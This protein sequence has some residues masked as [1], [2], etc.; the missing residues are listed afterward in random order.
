MRYL[1]RWWKLPVVLVVASAVLPAVTKAQHYTQ[2]NLVSN[3]AGQ[4]P[5]TDPNLQN[6]W[7][8][9]ASPGGSPWWVSDNANG[10]STLYSISGTTSLTAAII[11]INGNGI[12]TVPNA[13]SQPAPGSPTGIMFNGSATDFLLPTGKPAAFLFVTEDGTIQGWAGGTASTILVDHSQVPNAANGAVYKGATILAVD[14]QEF[15]LAAN[16][17]SGRIDIFNAAFKQVGFPFGAFED[18]FVPFGYAPFNVQGV[19]PNVYVTYAKQDA[20]RH[21]PVQPGLPGEGFVTVF[22]SHGRVIQRLER[23]PWFNAPW[24]VVW[25][26]PNFGQFSNTILIGN[27]RGDNISAFDPVTGRFL[28]NL[29]NADG[30]TILIDGLWALRFGNDASGGPATTLFFTAGPNNETNGLFGTLTPVTA[31]K[32]LGTQQ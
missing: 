27:F 11:P 32:N 28:G 17:R 18:P 2:T 5:V 29:L 13:P 22:D 8:L 4:A 7:G 15:I 1:S 31:E 21:D 12:V 23:G 6:P 30:S 19:G 10:V 26:T 24:G 16:F 20:Q 25:A 9:V 3:V 14:G